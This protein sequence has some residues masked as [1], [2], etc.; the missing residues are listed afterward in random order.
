MYHLVH[1]DAQ[2]LADAEKAVALAPRYADAIETRAEIYERLGRRVA[3]IADYRTALR[4][5][6]AWQRRRS[7]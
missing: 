2:G 5:E 7:G 4:P 6:P 1:R 3:A